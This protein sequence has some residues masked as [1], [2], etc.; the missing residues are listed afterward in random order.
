[1]KRNHILC[2]VAVAAVVCSSYSRY[3]SAC[4]GGTLHIEGTCEDPGDT[5][6]FEI[7]VADDAFDEYTVEWGTGIAELEMLCD[8]P[9]DP[10]CT[11]IT[12]LCPACPEGDPPGATTVYAHVMAADEVN[13]YWTFFELA[14]CPGEGSVTTPATLCQIQE[15]GQEANALRVASVLIVGGVVVCRRRRSERQRAS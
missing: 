13:H 5:V 6:W 7:E 15:G 12:V 9:D 14:Y 11:G 4:E 1:M 10:L 2:A 8:S 3:S